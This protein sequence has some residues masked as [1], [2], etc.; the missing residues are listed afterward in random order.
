VVSPTVATTLL[1]EALEASGRAPPATVE[2][3]R[4]FATGPLAEA[5]RRKLRDDDASQIHRRVSALFTRALDR[6]APGTASEVDVDVDL[7][8]GVDDDG[9]TTS[10]AVMTVVSRPVP[11]VV[12]SARSTFA[13]RLVLCL[14]EDRVKTIAVTDE[15]AL[16]KNV[17]AYSALVVVLDG[18]APTAV[19]GASLAAALRRLPN[20]ATTIVWASDA[21]G[22][23]ALAGALERA[24]AAAVTLGRADGI[25]PL[26]DLILSRRSE[27]CARPR[28]ALHVDQPT[29]HRLLR[30]REWLRTGKRCVSGRSRTSAASATTTRTTSSSARS[31]S[32]SSSA[33]AWAGT[34]RA[35]S[36]RRS[37]PRPCRK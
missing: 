25:E 3:M 31:S 13:E 12:L 33:T 1:F 7:D 30:P 17:F 22:G 10:T 15:A 20:G 32:S 2:E 16:S 35:R 23:A 6:K 18:A 27:D 34:R 14:G 21:D 11:V 36:P 9:D 5:V 8:L 24:G 28:A 29:R 19:D 26:L 37:P 4:A